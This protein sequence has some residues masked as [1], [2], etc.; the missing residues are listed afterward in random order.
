MNCDDVRIGIHKHVL[1][2]DELDDRTVTGFVL[3][4]I[5]MLLSLMDSAKELSWGSYWYL[6]TCC[7]ICWTQELRFE[8]VNVCN[9]TYCTVHA[10]LYI[11]ETFG[12]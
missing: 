6:Q 1:K 2:F 12:P 4:F 5:N 11:E 9:A 10:V 7:E 8:S 3:V